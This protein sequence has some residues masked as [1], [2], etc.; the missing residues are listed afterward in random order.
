MMPTVAG[1]AASVKLGA[2][3]AAVTLVLAVN[4]PEVPVMVIAWL[5][6]G[7]EL[8]AVSVR[9]DDPVAGFGE[10]DAV[11]PVGKAE[12][13][14]RLTLP[15]KPPA[16]VTDNVAVPVPPGLTGIVLCALPSQ[17]PGTCGPARS[18]INV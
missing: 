14:A 13:T 4:V 6:E 3:T 8:V 2:C 18:L 10:N 12:D 7:A 5:A 1:D 9:T 17:K 11:T 15:V 16:S